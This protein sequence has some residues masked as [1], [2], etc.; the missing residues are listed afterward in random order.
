MSNTPIHTHKAIMTVYSNAD[1]PTVSVRVEWEP[2]VTSKV[3]EDLGYLPASSQFIQQYVLPAI[4][5][6]Y[7]ANEV[8]PMLALESPSKR[9]N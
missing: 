6:A 4:E 5:E 1:D 2:D 3:V 7:M 8:E 9:V